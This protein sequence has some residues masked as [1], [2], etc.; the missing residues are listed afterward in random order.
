MEYIQG[1]GPEQA[2]HDS[3]Q[4]ARRAVLQSW[5]P[6]R[7]IALFTVCSWAK[8]FS[9][10]YIH[11]SIRQSLVGTF[12][13]D[14]DYIHVSS[15]GIIPHECE[16]WWP[17]CAYDWDNSKIS[18][19]AREVTFQLLRDIIQD[20]LLSF[21]WQF[22]VSSWKYILFYFREASNTAH[23]IDDALTFLGL[24][25]DLSRTRRI[26][27]SSELDASTTRYLRLLYDYV[28]PDAALITGRNLRMLS[29]ALQQLD[30]TAT[31][32]EVTEDVSR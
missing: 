24:E 10:S 32:K 16:T 20:H 28:D 6:K 27:V 2:Y 18:E 3:F 12:L 8:P 29:T 19:S 17:F 26:Y 22:P 14:I 5:R 30:L 1:Q 31:P 15:A 9:Q 25:V 13:S 11:T 7:P 21:L 4:K 23:A